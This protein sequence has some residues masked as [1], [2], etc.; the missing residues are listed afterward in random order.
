MHYLETIG[1]QTKKV[2]YEV[3]G[4]VVWGCSLVIAEMSEMIQAIAIDPK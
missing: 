2:Q 4:Y 1:Y 3:W